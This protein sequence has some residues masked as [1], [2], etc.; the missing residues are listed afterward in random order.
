MG[1]V[2][3]SHSDPGSFAFAVVPRGAG[4]VGAR[5][6]A[7]DDGRFGFGDTTS[8]AARTIILGD[9]GASRLTLVR[10][11]RGSGAGGGAFASTLLVCVMGTLAACAADL[12]SMLFAGSSSAAGCSFLVGGAGFFP[13]DAG[14][15]FGGLGMG[16]NAGGDMSP[17]ALT[18]T[19]VGVMGLGFAGCGASFFCLGVTTSTSLST[20]VGVTGLG[21]GFVLAFSRPSS[22]PSLAAFARAG[23]SSLSGV[24]SL[25]LGLALR[26][27]GSTSSP[28]SNMLIR[29]PVAG[30]DVVSGRPGPSSSPYSSSDLL[31]A[32]CR[33][34]CSWFTCA[35]VSADGLACGWGVGDALRE[36]A[37]VAAM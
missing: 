15:G 2:E 12:D 35:G 29:R 7:L 14:G 3:D 21:F 26:F 23:L 16:L 4:G 1:T 8:V 10:D 32:L 5:T 27:T 11:R 31:C 28:L 37:S 34:C 6:L 25:C 30:I 19:T 36:A 13:G 9:S 33:I 17:E 18:S 24:G 22:I 20:G